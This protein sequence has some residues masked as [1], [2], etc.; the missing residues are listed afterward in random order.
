[1]ALQIDVVSD[2]VCPWCFIGKRQLGDA[3]LSLGGPRKIQWHPMQIYPEIPEQGAKKDDFLV[4]KY[5]SLEGVHKAMDILTKT[6]D[7]FG[8]RFDFDRISKIPNTLDAH[9]IIYASHA[10][11]QSRLVDRL[12]SAFFEQ[13]LDISDRD[14]LLGVA[15]ASELEPAT[16]TKALDDD[17]TREAVLYEQERFKNLGLSGIPNILLNKQ[18]S[19]RG[20]RDTESLVRAFD[21]ALF[22]VPQ[23]EQPPPVIH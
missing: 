9:R 5:G 1:M 14:V 11:Q 19:I 2:L 8:I 23:K 16:T 4:K 7:E 3:M 20:A 15:E 12:F 6:G 21:L 17:A 10:G 22:G 13:G 18:F